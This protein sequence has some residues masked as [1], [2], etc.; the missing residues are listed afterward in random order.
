MTND[1]RNPN[2]EYRQA[3]FLGW[4]AHPDQ[5]EGRGRKPN[6]A[7]HALR[8]TSGRATRKL[9]PD[10][11]RPSSERQDAGES[12]LHHIQT[13]DDGACD[14]AERREGESR[15]IGVQRVDAVGGEIGR[16]VQLLVGPFVFQA[17]RQS[18]I[19]Q[20]AVVDDDETHTGDCSQL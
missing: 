3:L 13:T 9:G 20:R 18:D 10:R 6:E 14:A 19:R 8:K 17:Q 16:T 15:E 11:T 1:E 7:R 12:R 2:D 4:V 5:R